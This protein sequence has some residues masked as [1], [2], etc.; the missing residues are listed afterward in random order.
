MNGQTTQKNTVSYEILQM[1][2]LGLAYK[3]NLK[4]TGEPTTT[5]IKEIKRDW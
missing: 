5:A 4:P 3:P 1:T 2:A